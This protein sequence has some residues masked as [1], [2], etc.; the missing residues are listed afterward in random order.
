MTSLKGSA[1]KLKEEIP[2]VQTVDASRND[3]RQAPTP[4]DSVGDYAGLER[5]R[6][7]RQ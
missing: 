4:H 7:R 2:T 3:H 1:K 5:K 6:E